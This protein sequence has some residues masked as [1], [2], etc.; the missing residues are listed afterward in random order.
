MF[1]DEAGAL[2]LANP[3]I[4]V[5]LVAAAVGLVYWC[6]RWLEDGK[7]PLPRRAAGQLRDGALRGR[8]IRQRQAIR[9][10]VLT[11]ARFSSANGP[12]LRVV[13]KA[14]APRSAA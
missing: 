14:G 13:G 6:H 10:S 9:P 11:V 8:R 3:W 1:V 2:W 12:A 7:A 4:A 5:V